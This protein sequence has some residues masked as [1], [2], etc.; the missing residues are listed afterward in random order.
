VSERDEA[1][2]G[3]RSASNYETTR[4]IGVVFTPPAFRSQKAKA[5]DLWLDCLTEQAISDDI[6][7]PQQTVNRITQKRNDP[8]LGNAPDRRQHFD[9]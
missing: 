2:G 1:S 8:E 7:V 9:V 3:P 6:G 5:W 4:H